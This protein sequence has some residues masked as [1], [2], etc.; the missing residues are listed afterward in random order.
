MEDSFDSDE[1]SRDTSLLTQFTCI[2]NEDEEEAG[3]EEQ[4]EEQEFK[5]TFNYWKDRNVPG[6]KPLPF[7][8]N[9][10]DTTLRR[11]HIAEVFKSIYDAYPNEKV[12]GVYRMTTPCLLLRDLD[13]IKHVMIKD[14]DLFVD[15][16]VEFSKEGLGVNLFHADGDTW[17]VLRN[18]FTPVFTSG[19]LRNMLYLMTERGEQFI[20]GI[21]F[22][23]EGLGLNL[24]H[25]D[26]DTWR[27]LRN[28]FTPV[29]T[30]GKLRNM[31]YLMTERGEHFIEYVDNL[32]VKQPE[33]PIHV[34]VQKFTMATISACAFGMDLDEDMYNILDKIDKMIFTANYSIELDMMFPGILKKLSGSIFPKYVN[35][36]FDNLAQTVVKQ[37]G[38]LPTNRKD[39]M[40]L[41][42][43]LRQQ[44]TIEGTKKVDNEKLRIVELT[45]SVIAA[46][47]FVFYAAG[48]ETSASTMTYLFYELAKHPEI[49]DKVI[50]EID[51]VLKRHNGEITYDCLNEMTYLQQVFDETLRKYPIVD[52]LQRNAQTD[53][54]I[55]GTNV[56]VKKGQ[57]LLVNP[58]GIHYDPKYYP[59]PEKFD[60]ERF[61]PENEKDRHS[62]AYLPFGTGPRNC[63]GIRFAKV[64]SRVC[65]VKFL[66]K[67]RVEPSKKTP[68]VLE[69]DPMRLV[70]FPKGGIHLNVLC[71]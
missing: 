9:L 3:E 12:V 63:I 54:V 17:K 45:D 60:P 61:S 31:L 66:S 29:F 59:N 68:M 33:Q 41:I 69:Y 53:Y 49:Q 22:S 15:R 35:T 52:P 56:T 57:T 26:G 24:F 44:K 71:R 7:F 50:A 51:E 48:Y 42:L 2:Q 19:K 36:F 65:I 30:S 34:L 32:R 67:F 28:R 62:C 1:V 47:A 4:E 58:M 6:P 8:G 16:G 46:Q 70:L 10:K 38:G 64:Q 18:R 23:K 13:V 39:F 43:A 27:V 11:K 37:R 40:D 25:A 21:E 55:P 20:E 5:T 14:F